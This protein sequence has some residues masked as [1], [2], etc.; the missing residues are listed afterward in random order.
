MTRP[1]HTATCLRADQVPPLAGASGEP[2]QSFWLFPL[3]LGLLGAGYA[4]LPAKRL[5]CQCGPVTRDS[6]IR[7]TIF[8]DTCMLPLSMPVSNR[9]TTLLST[10]R[11]G[12]AKFDL[13]AEHASKHITIC[14]RHYGKVL[15][16]ST[17][18]KKCTT[19]ESTLELAKL[20]RKNWKFGGHT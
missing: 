3:L 8:S 13:G 15:G 4:R 10:S 20:V 11:A 18:V 12:L 14:I 7:L 19:M 16:K 1:P 17:W 6:R 5:R 2:C 9:A